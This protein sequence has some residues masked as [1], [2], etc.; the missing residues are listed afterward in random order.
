MKATKIVAR[1]ASANSNK[2][3]SKTETLQCTDVNE[4]CASLPQFFDPKYEFSAPQF[5]DFI[6]PKC[7]ANVDLWFDGRTSTCSVDHKLE[8]FFGGLTLLQNRENISTS[9]KLIRNANVHSNPKGKQ[10]QSAIATNKP[11]KLVNA[12]RKPL[13]VLSVTSSANQRPIAS[14]P[15]TKSTPNIPVK[16]AISK[17]VTVPKPFNLGRRDK[18]IDKKGKILSTQEPAIKTKV[19]HTTATGAK[20]TKAGAIFKKKPMLENHIATTQRRNIPIPSSRKVLQKSKIVQA[21]PKADKAPTQNTLEDAQQEKALELSLTQL[22]EAL[23]TPSKM[24]EPSSAGKLTQVEEKCQQPFSKLLTIPESPDLATKERALVHQRSVEDCKTQ[25]SEKVHI[26]RAHV[27]AQPPRHDF[28]PTQPIG[29]DLMTEHRGELH[30]QQ[31]KLKLRL[32]HEE[33]GQGRFFKAKPPPKSLFE[34]EIPPKP[35]VFITQPEPFSLEVDKRGAKAAVE[36]F[37][38]LEKELMMQEEACRFRARPNNS[39]TTSPFQILKSER[40]LTVPED[41]ELHTEKRHHERV[42][43]DHQVQQRE[44]DALRVKLMEAYE[45]AEREAAEIMELRKQLVH[46]PIPIAKSAPVEIHPSDQPLTTPISPILLTKIRA[47]RCHT[48]DE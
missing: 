36:F 31:F 44:E 39:A 18:P 15:M 3:V 26:N 41:I 8:N 16:K 2:I 1:T 42:E 47:L 4:R 33:L 24:N 21:A 5:H 11:T 10:P 7:E 13:Q 38:M 20:I 32:V 30:H 17:P 6:E 23:N 40:P 22:V 37:E 12:S 14:K 35:P 29:F 27:I 43:F 9:N 34:P 19:L 45:K 25:P 48:E 46:K 28:V